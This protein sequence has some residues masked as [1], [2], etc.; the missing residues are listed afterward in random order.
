MNTTTMNSW[1]KIS[2]SIASK[3]TLWSELNYWRKDMCTG[4]VA[5]RRQELN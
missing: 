3:T 1:K 4:L 5:E 2:F